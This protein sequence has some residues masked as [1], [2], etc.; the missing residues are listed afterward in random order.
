MRRAEPRPEGRGDRRSRLLWFVALYG[1]GLAAIA[2]VSYA[3]RAL[4]AL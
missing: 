1:A 3:L 4:I 2:A